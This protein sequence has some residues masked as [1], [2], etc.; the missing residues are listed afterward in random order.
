MFN[1]ERRPRWGILYMALPL[2]AGLFWLQM[3]APLPEVGH[4]AAEVGV[5]LLTF[6][7]VELWLRANRL[8]ILNEDYR[9]HGKRGWKSRI[10]VIFMEEI[11]VEEPGDAR[12]E[13]DLPPVV[14]VSANGQGHV[15]RTVVTAWSPSDSGPLPIQHSKFDSTLNPWTLGEEE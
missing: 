5:V 1:Q 3:Q 15:P 6:G 9:N 7:L 14:R 13:P 12:V 2:A 4:R 8:A 11:R 10:R